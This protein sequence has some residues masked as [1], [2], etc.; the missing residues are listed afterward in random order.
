MGRRRPPPEKAVNKL[1]HVNLAPGRSWFAFDIFRDGEALR[2]HIRR[3]KKTMK[4]LPRT[5]WNSPPSA[6]TGSTQGSD[7]HPATRA[8][9]PSHIR[10]SGLGCVSSTFSKSKLWTN[11]SPPR[12]TLRNL[13]TQ[14]NPL[15]SPQGPWS[16]SACSAGGPCS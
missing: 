16:F 1:R 2:A 10:Q 8:H 15:S 12:C 9:S 13:N 7:N 6:H 11:V 5:K 4:G 3:I 14:R